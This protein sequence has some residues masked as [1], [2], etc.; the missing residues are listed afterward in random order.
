MGRGGVGEFLMVRGEGSRT[1]ARKRNKGGKKRRGEKEERRGEEGR[2]EGGGRKE[3]WRSGK[4]KGGEGI[5]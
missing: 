4:R 1:L 3:E 5:Y 2:E